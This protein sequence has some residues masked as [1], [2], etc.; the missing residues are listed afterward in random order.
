MKTKTTLRKRT[1]FVCSLLS[2]LGVS[3]PAR[4]DYEPNKYTEAGTNLVLEYNLYVPDGVVAGTKYPL[5]VYLHAANNEAMPM[6][7]LSSD[8]KG[9]VPQLMTVDG[10]KTKAFYMIPISQTNSSGWG[11]PVGAITGPQKFEGRLTV[12]VLKELLTKYPIDPDR[13]YVTGASMGARGTYDLL[14]R[15]PD[16]FAA[17]APAASPA[18]PADAAI[19]ARQNIW[20]IMGS[21]DPVVQPNRDTI[22]AI[23]KACGNP[24]YTELAEHGHDSWRSI[25]PMPEFIAWM[26]AQR[27]GVPWTEVS[28][29]PTPE[30]ILAAE[31]A[32]VKG[33]NA[34][35]PLVV[36]PSCTPPGLG[37]SGGS[38]SGSNAGGGASA[39][40]AGGVST[41][42]S[43]SGGSAGSNVASAGTAPS[44]GGQAPALGGSAGAPTTP[45][46]VAGSSSMS[47]ADP[48]DPGEE[49]AGCAC[50]TAGHDTKQS[51]LGL[52]GSLAALLGLALRRRRG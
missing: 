24:I 36:T 18:N 26:F 17:G 52:F 37:G 3:L 43:G 33:L 28:Q 15:Y 10:G 31:Q 32:P 49:A 50:R 42:P 6:R 7:T 51:A 9:W 13:L 29:A 39:S 47:G 22:A 21:V 20:A 30:Q 46:P 45:G 19:Y 23:R 8:G 4:A 2:T 35:Q 12:V 41:E 5:L 14:R 16:F 40:G 34:T 11:D 38:G 1:L 27:R 25:Y 44:A 48:V